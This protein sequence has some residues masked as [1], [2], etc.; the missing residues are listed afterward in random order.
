MMSECAVSRLY[1]FLSFFKLY[2]KDFQK[3]KREVAKVK[4]LQ[5]PVFYRIDSVY[6]GSYVALV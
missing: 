4:P 6:T 5:L 3:Q 2:C 1:F